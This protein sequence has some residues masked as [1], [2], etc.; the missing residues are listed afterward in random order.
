VI[1][2]WAQIDLTG[3]WSFRVKDAGVTY[4][5]LKQNGETITGTVAG[6]PQ[7]P[8]N[9][10][11]QGGKLHLVI[12]DPY[13]PGQT[14]YDGVVEGDK[15]TTSLTST[16]REPDQGVWERTTHDAIFPPRPPLP[17][18]R[19]LPDNGLA[20]TPPMG[21]NS[22]NKYHDRFDETV[23]RGTAAAMVSSG[24]RNAGYTYVVMDEG[25]TSERDAQGNIIPNGKFPHFKDLIDYIHS[26]GLKVGVYSSPG[27]E[28]C[29]GYRGSYQGS[30]GH[31]QQDANTFAAW[32]VDYLKY[33]WCSASRVY[34]NTREDLQGAY[35]IMGEALQRTGRPIVYSLCEYGRG[36]VWTWGAQT[37]GNLWRMTGDIQDHWDSMQKI[38]FAQ[39]QYAGFARTGHWNDPDMLEVGNGGMTAD[40]YRTHM[41][42]WCLLAAPLMAGND[43]RQ[44]TDETKSILMNTEVIA[45]DQDP[46]YK[47]VQVIAQE[48]STEVLMRPL[49]DGSVAVGLFNRGDQ[50]A[51]VSVPWE[52]L[53]L[54]SPLRAH[55]LWT[56]QDVRVSGVQFTATVPVHGVVLLRV[57]GPAALR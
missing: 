24:M 54:T 17:A 15:F 25:W 47:P 52:K 26:L 2:A 49:A 34:H 32:G 21:W 39:M 10:T 35:Q 20:R 19:E 16:G 48:G 56:H 51:E 6:A 36:D 45:I 40:E 42:L 12:T 43:L 27:P 23:V 37:G 4:Y 46:V 13:H 55:D 18:V 31:E 33:D 28:S 57:V 30:Y 50:P 44:M 1:P 3:Y 53:H 38:G 5:E 7:R 14:V 8:I 22:W 9:G 11:L 29:G 41:S